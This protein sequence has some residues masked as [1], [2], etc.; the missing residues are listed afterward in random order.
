MSEETVSKD[1]KLYDNSPFTID[2]LK[3]RGGSFLVVPV[4]KGQVFSREKFSND[5][6]M[7][8]NAALEFANNRIK[9]VYKELNVMNSQLSKE[10][11]KEV[12]QLGFLGVDIPEKFGGLDLD[13]TTAC[14]IL[15]SLSCGKS[16]S[17]MVTLSAHTGIGSLP[18]IWYG[19]ERQ[20][21][22][23]LSKIA[24]GEI[25]A[26]FALTEPNAG[27]DA[28]AGT[29]TATLNNEKTHYLL[30]GQKIYCTNGTWSDI[31][32]TFAK[33]DGKHYTAFIIDKECEGWVVGA[34]E[35]KMGIKGSST[36]TFFFENCKVP[37][38]NVIGKVGEGGPIAFNVL[39]AGRYKLGAT[40]AAGCKFT[41]EG[42]YEFAKE[43][44]QFNRSITEF[45]MIKNKFASML[46]RT[47]ESDSLVYMTSGSIDQAISSYSKDDPDYYMHVQKI[48]EDHA[49]E[50]SICKVACSESLAYIVDE[51]VQVLGGA[52]FI[53]EYDMACIYRD[54]RINRIFEGTNEVNRLI[55]SGYT[56]KKSILE[57]LPIRDLIA[58]IPDNWYQ[59]IQ[60][61][62]KFVKRE[63]D[64]IEFSRSCIAYFINELINI[65]GQDLK[66]DQWVVEPLA[67]CIISFCIMDTGFKKYKNID[68]DTNHGQEVARVLK[69]SVYDQYLSMVSNIKTISLYIDTNFSKA[70]S[71][72]LKKQIEH[73]DYEC[74]SIGLKKLIIEDF[75]KHGKYYLD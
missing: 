11:F 42:A 32:I 62:N 47:W 48:I 36:C 8:Q 50:A 51:G 57:E 60:C 65:Y 2:K 34:E 54:E 25:M 23:Y 18:L 31:C 39:Y 38:E 72:E 22:K 56:L 55:I 6:I 3:G 20:N 61:E 1:K 19:N 16:A 10:L 52:G 46:T 58:S 9:P 41:I 35:K 70:T 74:D 49:I 37:V 45:D 5:H 69:L 71:E 13:K 12:G 7:F 17:F 66:N 63:A 4:D 59:D 27:S 67:N 30:N 14:I 15:D 43:R 64:V 21:E 33:V 53:E 68:S 73:L 29:T 75:Y 28:M 26:C 44:Q 24:S 40:T